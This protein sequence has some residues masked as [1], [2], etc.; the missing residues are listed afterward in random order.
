VLLLNTLDDRHPGPVVVRQFCFYFLLGLILYFAHKN[1]VILIIT[2]V[3]FFYS[4]FG[5][6]EHYTDVGDISVS[7]RR[8]LL[9]QAWSIPVVEHLLRPIRVYFGR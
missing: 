7:S 8:R 3:V 1:N 9:G 6:S 4:L 5:F 2:V